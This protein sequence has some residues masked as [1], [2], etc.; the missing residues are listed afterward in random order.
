MSETE[1]KPGVPARL[2]AASIL[3]R[4]LRAGAWSNVALRDIDLEE[5]SDRALVR[6]LVYETIRKLE[7][8]DAG[9]EAVLDRPIATVEATVLDTMRIA[10][11]EMFFSR[12]PNH[13]AV[14]TAVEAVKAAGHSRA[15]GFVNG[16]LRSVSRSNP[17]E[18]SGRL[19]AAF[20]MPDWLTETLV[21]AW[22]E[23]ET[24][25]FFS[26][27]AEAA[28]LAIRPR[29]GA[30]VPSVAAPG[31]VAGSW[32]L[33]PGAEVPP[34]CVVQDPAS[35]AVVAAL[36]IEPGQRVLDPA[37]APGGK[38][39]QIADSGAGM[40]VASDLHG[41]R[42]RSAVRRLAKTAAM[43]H[44]VQADASAP[45]FRG[46]SFD[47]ILLDAPCS[48]LGTLRRRPEIRLKVTEGEVRRLA[49]QQRRMIEAAIPLLAPG[50][51]L[52]YSV[53]TVTPAETLE[54]VEGLR[55][56]APESLPGRRS[57][58]GLLMGPHL[59]DTDGMFIAVV[60]R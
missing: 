52:V 2:I 3:G 50:G 9:I 17:P 22:G 35:V 54:V 42:L 46:G 11:T 5:S 26:A 27:S 39:L 55:V 51:R 6:M 7:I 43:V 18:M 33:P 24:I 44:W 29:P 1:P 23:G 41:R 25:E 45:P 20:G 53:C 28:P 32:L 4:V 60:E 56:R 14:D 38:T 10:T 31:P 8:V 19:G 15:A 57:A 30:A 36:G 59:S 37:A 49:A 58:S 12:S 21:S 47:R 48:G 34:N 16:V 40:V 13:A